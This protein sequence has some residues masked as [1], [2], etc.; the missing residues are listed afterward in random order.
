MT[1]CESDYIVQIE[2]YHQ[3]FDWMWSKTQN[4]IFVE[5]INFDLNKY[6]FS[7]L[8]KHTGEEKQEKRLFVTVTVGTHGW[9]REKSF[10]FLS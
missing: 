6:I 3:I 7:I 8:R 1:F 2:V 9:V 5:E 4:R 10:H